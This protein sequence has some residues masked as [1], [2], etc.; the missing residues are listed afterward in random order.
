MSAAPTISIGTAAGVAAASRT[1]V[2]APSRSIVRSR[3]RT[4]RDSRSATRTGVAANDCVAGGWPDRSNLMPTSG[5]TSCKSARAMEPSTKVDTIRSSRFAGGATSSQATARAMPS[6]RSTASIVVCA[7][8]AAS[9]PWRPRK[10]RPTSDGDG[11]GDGEAAA[12]PMAMLQPALVGGPFGAAL[13]DN[14][15]GDS[16]VPRRPARGR[17]EQRSRQ[18]HRRTSDDRGAYTASRGKI[19]EAHDGGWRRAGSAGESAASEG[20]PLGTPLHEDVDQDR[21]G[22]GRDPDQ[23]EADSTRSR[24]PREEKI[25]ERAIGRR[26]GDDQGCLESLGTGAHPCALE[27][28]AATASL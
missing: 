20:E 17:D 16:R 3:W 1:D 18:R 19:L 2:V 7:A 5:G 11:A 27:K 22:D 21:R 28:R 26:V 8:M 25:P 9:S 12:P 10:G 23:R 15:A 4:S 6:R 24:V 14:C 13:H